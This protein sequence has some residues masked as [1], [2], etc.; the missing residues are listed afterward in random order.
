MLKSEPARTQI[1]LHSVSLLSQKELTQSW[2]HL[3]GL[4][5]I[6]PLGKIGPSFYKRAVNARRVGKPGNVDMSDSQLR[7]RLLPVVRHGP[8]P[9][10]E[11]RRRLDE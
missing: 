9:R 4:A 6:I 7:R 2:L 5:F 11:K 3:S 1:K 10:K 8:E